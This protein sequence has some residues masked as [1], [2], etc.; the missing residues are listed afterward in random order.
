VSQQGGVV[1]Q[2]ARYGASEVVSLDHHGAE[3]TQA[4]QLRWDRA[5]EEVELEVKELEPREVAYGGRD[6]TGQGVV[7]EVK[8]LEARGENGTGLPGGY[9]IRVLKIP[10]F[11]GTGYG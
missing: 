2:I 5:R 1:E 7:A 8:D 6:A 4:P 10:G 11:S 9:R 3:L